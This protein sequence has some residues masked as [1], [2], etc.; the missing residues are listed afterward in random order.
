MTVR[1]TLRGGDFGSLNTPSLVKTGWR[2]GVVNDG[3]GEVVE[4]SKGVPEDVDHVKLPS[5]K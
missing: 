2:I 4:E 3:G 5:C 1:R